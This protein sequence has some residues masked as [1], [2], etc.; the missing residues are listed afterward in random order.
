M[1][2]DTPESGLMMSDPTH[3]GHGFTGGNGLDA[4]RFD[5]WSRAMTT[6][7]RRSMLG[8]VVMATLGLTVSPLINLRAV[9]QR[10]APA[11]VAFCRMLDEIG[12]LDP[13]LHPGR[14]RRG[15]QRPI[16]S[17]SQE[18]FR[19]LLRTTTR[20]ADARG[21]E[22]GGVHRSREAHGGIAPLQTGNTAVERTRPGSQS[23]MTT[24]GPLGGY[25]SV[26]AS[27]SQTR[28]ACPS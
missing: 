9:A 13:E 24:R 5:R 14:V 4:S 2:L 17:T 16:Q 11:A 12:E 27:G 23:R 19:W 8:G 3:Q 7:S 10:S 6:G 26:S 1:C 15:S 22:Q 20:S 25:V 21:Q 18:P 28:S